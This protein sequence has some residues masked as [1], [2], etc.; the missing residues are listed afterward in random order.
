MSLFITKLDSTKHSRT[1]LR[2]IMFKKSQNP[3]HTEYIAGRF[4]YQRTPE[5]TFP[6]HRNGWLKNHKKK[7]KHQTLSALCQER[8]VNTEK[9]SL[10]IN[11]DNARRAIS[12]FEITPAL[13]YIQVFD[14]ISHLTFVMFYLKLEKSRGRQL[15]V[16]SLGRAII[17]AEPQQSRVRNLPHITLSFQCYNIASLNYR[18]RD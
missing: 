12:H 13:S 3:Y 16:V 14:P 4:A 10:R 7:K 5:A 8:R 11:S 17:M 2:T 6:S 1:S 9:R 18:S 15:D